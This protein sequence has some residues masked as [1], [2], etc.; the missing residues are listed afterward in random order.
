MGTLPCVYHTSNHA[1]GESW[2]VSILY[3]SR[4]GHCVSLP[5]SQ[6]L[7]QVGLARE[8]V[9]LQRDLFVVKWAEI[10]VCTAPPSHFIA[11]LLRTAS[12]SSFSTR[13]SIRPAPCGRTH[14]E[15]DSNATR[16]KISVSIY[17]SLWTRGCSRKMLFSKVF[18]AIAQVEITSK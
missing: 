2:P 3:I 6:L 11:N 9:Q 13:L 8:V 18:F 14:P 4:L 7:S 5:A 17:I 10:A 16:C 15:N 1:N 12:S